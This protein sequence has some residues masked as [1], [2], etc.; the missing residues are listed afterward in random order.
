MPNIEDIDADNTL[1]ENQSYYQYKIDLRK[2]NLNI[3]DN[4]YI[5]QVIENKGPQ[6]NTNWYLFR[7]PIRDV[8]KQAFNGITNFK[9]IRFMR[10]FLHGFNEEVILR[11]ATLSMVRGNWRQYNNLTDASNGSLKLIA[12]V[13]IEEN[14]LKSPIPYVLPPGIQRERIQGAAASTIQMSN[15]YL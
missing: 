13:N 6:K 7:I 9:S 5:T 3:Q 4:K 1:N 10:M 15:L 14:G 2:D 12:S 8:D 11:F